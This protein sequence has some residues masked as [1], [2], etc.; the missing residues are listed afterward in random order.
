MSHKTTCMNGNEEEH[1]VPAGVTEQLLLLGHAMHARRLL[2][3]VVKER[4]EEKECQHVTGSRRGGVTQQV[5]GTTK[6]SYTACSVH[7]SLHGLPSR[8]LP[9]KCHHAR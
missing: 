6:S 2:Y 1:G 3:R 5:R 8:F 9:G 4:R 7:P